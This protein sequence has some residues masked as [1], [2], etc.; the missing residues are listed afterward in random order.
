MKRLKT[1][2][3]DKIL[4]NLKNMIGESF[5]TNIYEEISIQS[6]HKEYNK[7]VYEIL[8]YRVDKKQEMRYLN[9]IKED[10]RANF[11]RRLLDKLKVMKMTLHSYIKKRHLIDANAFDKFQGWIDVNESQ[12]EEMNMMSDR[13]NCTQTDFGLVK[14]DMEN[15]VNNFRLKS[16]YCYDFM[17]HPQ[18]N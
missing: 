12:M 18:Y 4:Q 16:V 2:E 17:E 1:A 7:T 15:E 3:V 13:L 11:R 9:F 8:D 6:L 14:T 10:Y 5:S